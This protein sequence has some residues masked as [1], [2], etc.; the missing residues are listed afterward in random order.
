MGTVYKPKDLSKKY[1]KK[2]SDESLKDIIPETAAD[3][4]SSTEKNKEND[5]TIF[6]KD[7]YRF[8]LFIV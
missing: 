3:D 1:R 5:W 2:I 4:D 7:Q 8:H 6:L